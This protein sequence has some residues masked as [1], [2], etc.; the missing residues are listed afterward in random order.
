MMS[1]ISYPEVVLQMGVGVGHVAVA[2]AARTARRT[3]YTL[4]NVRF[5]D[6]PSSAWV[7]HHH[8]NQHR[9]LERRSQLVRVLEK[10]GQLVRVLERRGQLVRVL[11]RRGQLVRF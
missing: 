6:S 11:E 4:R 3:P 10:R 2:C 5:A 1:V 7:V 9:V 8:R